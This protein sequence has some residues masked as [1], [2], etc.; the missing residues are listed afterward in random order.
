MAQR[1]E[2]QVA[3]ISGAARGMGAAEARAFAAAGARVVLG[4]ILDAEGEQVA[5]EIGKAAR[6]LHLDVT[7]ESS[8]LTAVEQAEA[9]FGRIDVLVNNA[10]VVHFASVADV[11]VEDFRRVMEIN[12]TGT[13]LGIKTATPALRQLGGGAVVN[14]SSITGLKGAAGSAAYVASK[15]AVRGLTKAAA[16]DLAPD[17][18]RVNSVH[19]G[20]IET[21]MVM[22]RGRPREEILERHLP[23][24]LIPRLGTPDDVVPLVLFLASAEA[25]Y[26]TGAE[27]V[28]DGGWTVR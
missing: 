19:P 5:A 9:A 15:W 1:F 18:I 27:F 14:I 17:G 7:D 23:R 3:L 20:V 16:A 8:W 13:L 22:G 4:D 2:G 25:S 6:Y 12:V 24:L 11:D 10:G 21:P 26:V 28:V